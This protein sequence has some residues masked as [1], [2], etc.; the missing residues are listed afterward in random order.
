MKDVSV[1]VKQL[2]SSE[3]TQRRQA[4]TSLVDMGG[5][6]IEY[7]IAALYDE[8]PLIRCQAAIALYEIRNP[9]TPY[10][11]VKDLEDDNP[12]KRWDAAENLVCYDRAGV[13]ALLEA[14]THRFD[15][16]LLRAGAHHV[17]RTLK[18]NGRLTPEEIKVLDS[19]NNL[20]SSALVPWAAQAALESLKQSGCLEDVPVRSR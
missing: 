11:L 3:I 19:F 5:D 1:L 6:S 2:G 8:D 14:L 17:F 4:R 18:K 13:L 10:A 7:L 20:I 12:V 16:P 9:H 15:S